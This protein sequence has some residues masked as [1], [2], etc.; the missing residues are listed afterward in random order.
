ME[1]LNNERPQAIRAGNVLNKGVNFN[2]ETQP[3]VNTDVDSADVIYCLIKRVKQRWPSITAQRQVSPP[4]PHTLPWYTNPDTQQLFWIQKSI[5]NWSNPSV[6][7]LKCDFF[8][9]GKHCRMRLLKLIG[10]LMIVV[11]IFHQD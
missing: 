9:T 10:C 3:R 6:T 7:L 8:L 11:D 1:K 4:S 2:T 5:G